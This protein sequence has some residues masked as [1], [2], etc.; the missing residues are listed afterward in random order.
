MSVTATA[1]RVLV[2]QHRSS[3]AC[4]W[5]STRS[6][7]F[8]WLLTVAV[9]SIIFSRSHELVV[10]VV[11]KR[12]SLTAVF[13]ACA[14]CL[15]RHTTVMHFLLTRSGACACAY[16]NPRE[17]EPFPGNDAAFTAVWSVCPIR[18]KHVSLP[19]S[20]LI[21]AQ[22]RIFKHVFLTWH[23]KSEHL[24]HPARGFVLCRRIRRST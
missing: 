7:M 10:P 17:E 16:R 22:G 23:R 12:I 2:L 5:R 15:F 13:Q 18:P 19:R 9:P 14:F 24:D 8:R 21:V 4:R 1:V 11:S 20:P 3:V 6:K